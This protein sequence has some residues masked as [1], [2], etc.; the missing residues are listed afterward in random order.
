M[1][2]DVSAKEQTTNET[3]MNSGLLLSPAEQVLIDALRNGDNHDITKALVEALGAELPTPAPV[4]P[5]KNPHQCDM[6]RQ[7][8]CFLF[9]MMALDGC[10]TPAQTEDNGK[11]G[12]IIES[13]TA[14][15][16]AAVPGWTFG[17]FASLQEL[18]D[19][20]EWGHDAY[21]ARRSMKE[22]DNA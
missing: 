6:D 8:A 13:L 20:A 10:L 5:V 17:N 15:L 11:I 16:A 2:T 22:G 19:S 21:L 4:P 12:Q 9:G 7:Y 18:Y 3:P 14:G 1:Q